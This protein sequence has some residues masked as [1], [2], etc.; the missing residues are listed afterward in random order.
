M[1]KKKGFNDS[2]LMKRYDPVLLEETGYVFRA[3]LYYQALEQKPKDKIYS[4]NYQGG[5]KTLFTR[6]YVSGKSKKGASKL[7]GDL[8]KSCFLASNAGFI[9]KEIM[10]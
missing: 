7:N 9:T 1:L 8:E 2:M 10:N 6:H 4:V 3:S 5:N